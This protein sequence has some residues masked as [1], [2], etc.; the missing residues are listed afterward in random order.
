MTVV[1]RP[2]PLDAD[3][4]DRTNR[5]QLAA[6]TGIRLPLALWVVSHHLSGS[7][8]MLEP[9]TTKSPSVHL[10]VDEAWAAV[11]V[12]F[13]ISG[14]VITRRYR[15]TIWTRDAWTRYT[16]AR[17][18]R[19][20]PVY[21]LSLLIVFPIAFEAAQQYPVAE[22]TSL[23][24]NHLLLLQGWHLPPVNWNTPAWSLSCEVFFYACAPLVLLPLR[25]TSRRGALGTAIVACALP[26]VTRLLIAPPIPKA[27]LYFGDFLMGVA[28][29]ALYDQL[30]QDGTRRVARAGPWLYV[31]G[32]IGGVAVLLSRD[33]LGSFL[34]FDTGVR[35]A[36]ALIV[37]GLACGGGWPARL[38]TS[39]IAQA[40][41]RASYAIYI[42]HVPILWWYERSL[43]RAA[44]PLVPAGLLYV[45]LVVAVSLA[46]VRWYEAPAN[47]TVRRWASGGAVRRPPLPSGVG[48]APG[49]AI[50]NE[51]SI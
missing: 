50:R 36:A 9:L 33:S 6:L 8:R 4:A 51:H 10:L 46:V 25:T 12:F 19:I 26:M 16:A 11:S 5:H 40:G 30:C 29:G 3:A 2:A 28:A 31:P 34:L 41:G 23:L 17:L 20:Y 14:F 1:Y 42:L 32:M 38:M 18:A 48:S 24:L 39:S 27:L 44:L 47:A 43:A 13:V 35:V 15:T 7:G 45:S 22:R 49:A 37:L 21:L